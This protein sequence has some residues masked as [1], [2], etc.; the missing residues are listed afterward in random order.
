MQ[1]STQIK[2]TYPSDIKIF[3]SFDS[4]WTASEMYFLATGYTCSK[5]HSEHY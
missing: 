5:L 2:Q 3:D 1:F 4:W